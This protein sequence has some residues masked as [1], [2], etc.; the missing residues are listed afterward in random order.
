MEG[1]FQKFFP[2]IKHQNCDITKFLIQQMNKIE[3]YI[4]ECH[5]LRQFIINRFVIFRL[6]IS[7]KKNS[8]LLNKYSSKSKDAHGNK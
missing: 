2:H 3:F 6:K 5:N 7:G 1:S 8:K 4:P